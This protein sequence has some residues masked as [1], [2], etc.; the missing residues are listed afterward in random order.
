LRFPIPAQWSL[1]CSRQWSLPIPTESFHILLWMQ[2][3]RLDTL[4]LSIRAIS[5]RCFSVIMFC[6]STIVESKCLFSDSSCWTRAWCS[7]EVRCICSENRE[8]PQR[9]TNY[10][11][12]SQ[13]KV[14]LDK[15]EALAIILIIV[16]RIAK[17]DGVNEK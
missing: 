11:L 16:L 12:F 9:Q 4:S 3:S 7:V 15:Y 6:L 17:A 14:K 2:S 13:R 8:L 10:A 5:S 1:S